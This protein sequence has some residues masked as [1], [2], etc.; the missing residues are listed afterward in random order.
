MFKRPNTRGKRRGGERPFTPPKQQGHQRHANAQP[1]GPQ[2]S[3]SDS[4][5]PKRASMHID[6]ATQKHIQHIVP[7]LTCLALDISDRIHVKV[8]SLGATP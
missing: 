6:K 7:S 2:P 8:T 5:C 4:T 3:T 1:Q